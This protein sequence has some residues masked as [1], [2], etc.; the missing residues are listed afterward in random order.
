[1]REHKSC[2]ENTFNFPYIEINLKMLNAHCNYR[3]YCSYYTLL[4]LPYAKCFC[5]QKCLYLCYIIKILNV[6]TLCVTI[7]S[8]QLTSPRPSSPPS[9]HSA[10]VPCTA[11]PHGTESFALLLICCFFFLCVCDS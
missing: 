8:P 3:V 7:N 1:M 6:F 2:R 4:V 9:C 11:L 5:T 10:P